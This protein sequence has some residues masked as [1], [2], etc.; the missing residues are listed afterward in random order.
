MLDIFRR[1]LKTGIV[2]S[3]YPEVPEPAPDVF[4][5]QV[6]LDTSRCRGTGDCMHACPS[7]AITVTNG[8]GGGWTWELDDSR[9]VFCSLCAEAC[10]A[11]ALRLS[12]EFELAARDRAGLVTRVAFKPEDGEAGS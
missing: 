7:A 12:N 2:T 10:P 11:V 4:R 9:C 3:G 8:D 6:L 1:S 5:G